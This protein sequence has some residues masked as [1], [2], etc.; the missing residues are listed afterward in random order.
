MD[1]PES[2]TSEQV[3]CPVTDDGFRNKRERVRKC[4][5]QQKK[6]WKHR[7]PSRGYIDPSA[8]CQGGISSMILSSVKAGAQPGEKLDR[9]KRSH[10]SS[11]RTEINDCEGTNKTNLSGHCE[12]PF[13]S[14]ECENSVGE[15]R[16]I[17]LHKMVRVG[18]KLFKCFHC[19]KCLK[20][21]HYVQLY[22]IT[23]T[24]NKPFKYCKCDSVS[25]KRSLQ[26]AH[27]VH[28]QFKC[29]KCDKYLGR[30]TKLDVH[31]RRHTGKKPFNCSECDK[32][33]K[34]MSE[35]EQHEMIHTGVKPFKC[36][37]CGKCFKSM[38][39]LKQHERVHT[40]VKPFKCSECDK[41]F[42]SKAHLKVHERIH[43]EEKP[44][45]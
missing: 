37:E 12:K 14:S 2:K 27:T 41:C 6:E 10:R 31:Q 32:C 22:E 4:N 3:H 13:K 26:V 7:D 39:K 33:F 9:E 17:E 40:G 1:P 8:D 45:K 38:P 28:K 35:L 23:H 16:S 19:D 20:S 24:G 5:E 29:S 18:H 21:K 25:Q 30:K 11:L 36:T 43:T 42:R 15:K 44:F 34:R